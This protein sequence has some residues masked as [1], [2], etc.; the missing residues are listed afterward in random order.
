M[1]WRFVRCLPLVALCTLSLGSV[2]AQQGSRVVQLELG[3]AVVTGFSGVQAPAPGTRLPAGK[4]AADLTFIDPDRPSARVV[5]LS[6]PGFVWDGRMFAAPKP[7]SVF[8]KDVG[9]VFGIALD[10]QT[11]PNI[12]LAATS[13]FGLNVVRRSAGGAFDRLKKG[14]P[15]AGWM[16]GQF[17]LDLQ[18]GPGAIYKIDGRTGAPTLF[19]NVTLDGSPNPGPALGNLAFDAARKQIFVSDLY[20]GMIHRFDLEDRK[21]TRLNPVTSLSRMPSSA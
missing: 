21:S 12:Y 16:R 7:F 17:G 2:H 10:D 20:T 3:D 4:S 18:G 15:G 8:A 6:R 9:Q 11:P 1:R 5:T 19:A 13:Q 14:A